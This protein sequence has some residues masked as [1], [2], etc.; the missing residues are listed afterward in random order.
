[1][2]WDLSESP[3][4]PGLCRKICD[5]LVEVKILF[6]SLRAGSPAAGQ[7]C[8]DILDALKGRSIGISITVSDPDM[9]VSILGRAEGAS[10]K[11]LLAEAASLDAVRSVIGH[12][13]WEG[14]ENPPFGISFEVTQDN[15]HEIPEVI[16]CCVQGGVRDLVFPIQRLET[17]E[18]VFSM[19]GKDREELSRALGGLDRRR[20]RL[21]IHDPFLW[22]VFFPD[23]DYHE[24]GC[25]AANSMLYISPSF[26]VW[27]CPAMPLEL[28]G[29]RETTLRDVV[30]SGKKKQVRDSLLRPPGECTGC[31]RS[32]KC[33]GGCRGR[34]YAMTGSLNRSDPACSV[35]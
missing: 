7:G 13:C 32:G 31:D 16:S 25:Q 4:A 29:L 12:K 33:L 34:A 28:G 9:A 6:L 22:E 14:E 2:Y 24:G 3:L 27:P 21:T 26:K 10:L 19:S 1:M 35:S 11:T 23:I 17:G 5:E 20:L 8:M 30:L 15:F 18:D